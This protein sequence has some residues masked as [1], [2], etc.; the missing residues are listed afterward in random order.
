MEAPLV[1]RRVVITGL[2]GGVGAAL[3]KQLLLL[4]AKVTLHHP[5]DEQT[6]T[7]ETLEVC[8]GLLR[9]SDV[10]DELPAALG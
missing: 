3:A 2:S 1:E 7:G 6:V 4:G 8:G 9:E 10:G 5:D